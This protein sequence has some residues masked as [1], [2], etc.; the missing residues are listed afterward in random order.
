MATIRR[1][2]AGDAAAIA[3]VEVE[4][5][6][7]TYAGVL[8]DRM[9]L[10][11]SERRLTAGWRDTI[12]R[13]GAAQHVA[14][15]DCRGVGVVGFGSCGPM[16][17]GALPYDGE[18]FTLYVLPDYQGRGIGRA[19]LA[20]LFATLAGAGRRSALIWVLAD[21]PS[22]FFYHA[23]GGALVAVRRERQWGTVLGEMAYG[24]R[25]LARAARPSGGLLA[26]RP[27]ST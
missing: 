24:W 6:R 22:R 2:C 11:M 7:E 23:M 19:L 13:A 8:P 12:A 15:A 21:N 16:R 20:K 17:T 27:R 3:R 25:D 9:L 26:R 5:W 14:V 10:G 1:A 4:T 18:V